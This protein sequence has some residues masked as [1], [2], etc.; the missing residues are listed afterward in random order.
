VASTRQFGTGALSVTA[1]GEV[2]GT[3]D[4]GI[5]ARISNTGSTGALTVTTGA[6]SIVS[7]GE[8]GI[9]AQQNGTGALSVTANGEVTGTNIHGISAQISNSYATG[10]LTITSGADSTV[11]GGAAGIQGLQFGIGALSITANGEVTG[12]S[13]GISAQ[14]LNPSTTGD[15]TV[16]TGADSAVTGFNGI[17]AEQFGTGGLSVTADGNIT[18][19]DRNGIIAQRSPFNTGSSADLTVTTGADSAVTGGEI[20]AFSGAAGR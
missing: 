15:L 20:L 5:Y 2:T 13:G 17:I 9:R 18:G 7:G 1:D 8:N 12:T 16:T 6:D 19:T 4:N 11:T 14:V 3:D 10:D